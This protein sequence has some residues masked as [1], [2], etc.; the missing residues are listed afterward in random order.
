MT[1]TSFDGTWTLLIGE[2]E[3][4]ADP[5][6]KIVVQGDKAWDAE[7][8]G[9]VGSFATAGRNVFITLPPS[10]GSGASTEIVAWPVGLRDLSGTMNIASAGDDDDG[11]SEPCRLI[12]S[13]SISMR[14]PAKVIEE[15]ARRA[16]Q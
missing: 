4:D 11:F 5:N 16:A 6:T 9:V 14:P 2:E 7:T 1:D 10:A 3:W 8:P 13:M 15:P 12:R